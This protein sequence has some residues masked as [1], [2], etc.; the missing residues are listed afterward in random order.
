MEIVITN[1]TL[2][3]WKKLWNNVLAFFYVLNSALI[4]EPTRVKA[5]SI[6]NLIDLV[7]KPLKNLCERNVS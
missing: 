3:F 2:N 7:L 5:F 6:F 4:F 1:E